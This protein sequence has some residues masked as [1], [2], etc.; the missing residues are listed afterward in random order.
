MLIRDCET[1]MY[2]NWYD[3]VEDESNEF[4]FF[5]DDYNEDLRAERDME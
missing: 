3:S 4:A 5:E 2:Y 1:R